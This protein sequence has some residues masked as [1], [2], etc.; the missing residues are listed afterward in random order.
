MCIK[1]WVK[2]LE[3]NII[4]YQ[5][6]LVAKFKWGYKS[7]ILITLFLKDSVLEN[8]ENIDNVLKKEYQKLI[9]W[10]QT[11]SQ[12]KENFRNYIIMEYRNENM[13][14]I[15]YAGEFTF[16]QNNLSFIQTNGAHYFVKSLHNIPTMTIVPIVREKLGEVCV[17]RSLV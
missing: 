8:K 5:R 1:R 17:I 7:D 14:E 10:I 11:D 16:D 4:G 2:Q 12:I 3:K 13:Q 9:S 15:V 6:Q